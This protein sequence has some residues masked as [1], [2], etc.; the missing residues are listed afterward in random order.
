MKNRKKYPIMKNQKKY[1]KICTVFSYNSKTNGGRHVL[2]A[3]L[4]STPQ[5]TYLPTYLPD[6]IAWLEFSPATSYFL[7]LTA[8]K[9][10]RLIISFSKII[11]LYNV[12]RY[13]P[14]NDE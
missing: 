7:M 10:M 12:T 3:D 9:I 6:F 4:D 1:P 2:I 14:V 5:N 13:S 11:R 8:A